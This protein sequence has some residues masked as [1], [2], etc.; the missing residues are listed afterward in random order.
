MLKDAVGCSEPVHLYTSCPR[1]RPRGGLGL[2]AQ[3]G[4]SH[5][6]MYLPQIPGFSHLLGWQ[7]SSWFGGTWG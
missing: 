2:G 7:L 5:S 6:R 1:L 4:P 3:L